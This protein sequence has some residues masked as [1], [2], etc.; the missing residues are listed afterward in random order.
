MEFQD[1]DMQF[2]TIKG[3]FKR[4]CPADEWTAH[5]VHGLRK[6]GMEPEPGPKLEGWMKNSGFINIHQQVLPIPVGVW[7]KDRKLVFISYRL[8]K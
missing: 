8:Q 4:G 2:Y 6:V 3:E 7:P 5:V 1:F